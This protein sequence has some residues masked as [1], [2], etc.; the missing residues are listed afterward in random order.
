MQTSDLVIESSLDCC[1]E[2]DLCVRFFSSF[3]VT[4]AHFVL[5][6]FTA[7]LMWNMLGSYYYGTAF[8]AT[9]LMTADQVRHAL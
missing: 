5:N 6:G 3:R 9:S 1:I 4:N 2:R 8:Y 7:S